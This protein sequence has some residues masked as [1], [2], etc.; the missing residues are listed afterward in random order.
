MQLLARAIKS[1]EKFS[2]ASENMVFGAIG[3]LFRRPKAAFGICGGDKTDCV[4]N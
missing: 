4:Q 2:M 1:N 3:S